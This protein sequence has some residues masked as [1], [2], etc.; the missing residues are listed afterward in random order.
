[1]RIL[2]LMKKC[3]K[4]EELRE[5]IKKETFS[6]E[7]ITREQFMEIVKIMNCYA[8]S[9]SGVNAQ[10]TATIKECY[11]TLRQEFYAHNNWIKRLYYQYILVV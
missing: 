1:M 11:V 3:Q 9:E 4:K 10:Q 2:K 6:V 8:Y 7:Q 5:V